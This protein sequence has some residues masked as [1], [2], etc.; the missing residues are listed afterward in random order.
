MAHLLLPSTYLH[1]SLEQ[2]TGNDEML[3]I[4]FY[5]VTL[6]HEQASQVA[7]KRELAL[8]QLLTVNLTAN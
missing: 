4:I 2:I 7:L 8:K 5:K 3:N 1:I 6:P